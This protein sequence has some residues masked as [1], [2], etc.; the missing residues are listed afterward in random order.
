MERWLV[1]SVAGLLYGDGTCR[2]FDFSAA[3]DNGSYN[4]Q[5]YYAQ[6]TDSY[7]PSSYSETVS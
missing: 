3:E 2:Q 4:S 6:Q 5:P 7:A 1:Q